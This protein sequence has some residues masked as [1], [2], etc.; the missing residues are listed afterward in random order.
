MIFKAI[1]LILFLAI[2][3]VMYARFIKW[4]DRDAYETVIKWFRKN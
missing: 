4:Y 3:C 2:T 1:E